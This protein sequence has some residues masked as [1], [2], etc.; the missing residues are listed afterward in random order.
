MRQIPVMFEN[1][2]LDTEKL[3]KVHETLG[4]VEMFLK[5]NEGHFIAGN[6]LTIVGFSLAVV[7]S[8][9]GACDIGLTNFPEYRAYLGRC[10]SMMRS[11]DEMN[12]AGAKLYGQGFKAGLAKSKE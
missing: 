8:T 3:E 2:P 9:M 1:K 12:H 5:Q 4:Y 6:D 7:L 11:L 10:S